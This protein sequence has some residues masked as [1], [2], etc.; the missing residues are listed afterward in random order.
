MKKASYALERG[1][2]WP[3]KMLSDSEFYK[4]RCVPFTGI[5][6]PRND[7]EPAL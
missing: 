1:H 2:N 3:Y 5:F 7:K 4:I 6:H